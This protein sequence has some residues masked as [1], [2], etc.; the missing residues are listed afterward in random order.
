MKVDMNAFQYTALPARVIFGSGTLKQVREEMQALG[1]RRA[2]ILS[3]AHHAAGAAADLAA[4]LGPLAAG[5]STDAVMHTPVEITLRVMAKLDQLG[6][7]CLIAVGGGST[8]G[9]SKALALRTN[10]PQI[11]V[12]TTYAGSEAT[13]ILGQTE[14][15]VKTTLRS[16]DVL[17]EVIVYDVDLTIDLPVKISVTSGINAIAHAVEA[18]YAKDA[19]PV[20]SLLAEKGIEALGFA[21]PRIAE[22]MRDREARRQAL[23]GAWMCGTCL[24]AVGMSLHHKLCHTLGGRFNLPH[25]ETHAIVLPHAAA[26]NADAAPLAMERVARALGVDHAP[27]GLFDL[28]RQ[29]GAPTAL[30]DIGMA[31]LDIEVAV[32]AA[33]A[34]PYWNPAPVQRNRLRALLENAFFG[35]R[36]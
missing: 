27:S 20:T 25:A 13:P 5:I 16:M 35:N 4:V 19:N 31:E 12:P 10:L 26:Y 28:A 24:G 34:A 14:N 1:C 23:L 6:I 21:L 36:P 33:L 29:L 30:K 8:I 3:D 9:L 17:P 11:V 2:L 18:L 22:D 7:D 15:D 32:E